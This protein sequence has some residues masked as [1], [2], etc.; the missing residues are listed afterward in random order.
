MVGRRKDER[1][2]QNT[3]QQATGDLQTVVLIL[4]LR[5]RAAASVVY[6][7]QAS[8][9]SSFDDS[10]QG[11]SRLPVFNYWTTLPRT[12][13]S[14]APTDPGTYFLSYPT[15]PFSNCHRKH[16]T[17]L[18]GSL[19]LSLSLYLFLSITRSVSLCD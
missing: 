2:L 16:N 10:S 17:V 15:L 19:S 5:A 7:F 3:I 1:E 9:H 13:V 8:S 11:P 4:R 14:S 6:L 18:F 12:E